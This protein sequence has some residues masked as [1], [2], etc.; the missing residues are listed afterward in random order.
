MM[1]R[2]NSLLCLAAAAALLG[3]AATAAAQTR[4]TVER[5]VGDGR[6]LGAETRNWVELQVSGDAA[7]AN[8]PVMEGELAGHVWKRYAD[9]FTQPIPATFD[10]E[11]FTDER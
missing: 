10:R 11:G 8:A 9:S 4:Q 6:P 7:S 5:R 2:M 3:A 1:P